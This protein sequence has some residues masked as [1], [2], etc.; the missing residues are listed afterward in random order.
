MKSDVWETWSPEWAPFV[1]GQFT[2]R[3]FDE[4]GL[5][6]EQ[7]IVVSCSSCGATWQRTCTSG[8]VKNHINTFARLHI[9]RDPMAPKQ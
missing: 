6:D 3:T 7:R 8:L 5:P 4:D 9:H 2:K 1:Q